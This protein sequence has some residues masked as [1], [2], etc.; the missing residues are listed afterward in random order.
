MFPT[1]LIAGN[2]AN[3]TSPTDILDYTIADEVLSVD[4]SL[5][6]N[7][8]GV[9]LGVKTSDKVYNHTKASCDRLK[10]AEILSVQAVKLEGYHFLMQRIK[11]RNGVIEYAISFATAKNNNDTN[12]SIQTNW[13]VN[14]YTKFNDC[15]LYT[16]PSP[17]D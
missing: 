7:T 5:D 1:E 6:G 8:K 4:F 3:V 15:L 12:Y 9:V 16:S 17:R 14:N 2:L 10:G 13:Y 11:Q